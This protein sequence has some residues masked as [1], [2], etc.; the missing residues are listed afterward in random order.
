MNKNA[1]LHGTHQTCAA[2]EHE[3]KVMYLKVK[4][5][6]ELTMKNKV[7]MFM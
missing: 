4:L 5:I 3:K 2:Q 1:T 7:I 6:I